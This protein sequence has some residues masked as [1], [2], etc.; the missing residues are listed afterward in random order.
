MCCSA[1][2]TRTKLSGTSGKKAGLKIAAAAKPRVRATTL[3]G[4]RRKDIVQAAIKLFSRRGYEA[5]R[6]VDIAQAAKIAK[7]TLYL[8]FRSKEAIYSAAIAHAVAELQALSAERT[9]TVT[10]FR[11][12][13]SAAI[14]VRLHFW[15]EHESLYRLLLTLGREPRHRRQTNELL[16]SGKS[17]LLTLFTEEAKVEEPVSVEYEALAW[18][19]LDMVRGATERRLDRLSATTVESDVNAITA[20]ALRGAEGLPGWL[21]EA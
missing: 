16:R 12:K 7:G 4:L 13:I 10:C 6:A 9:G 15:T 11:D 17:D 8:Y 2:A 18:A 1:A 21:P 5:T 20:F 3:T 19:V 14:A